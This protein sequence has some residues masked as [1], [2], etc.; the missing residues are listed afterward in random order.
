METNIH[1]DVSKNDFQKYCDTH[2]DSWVQE[3]GFE[4]GR[5]TYPDRKINNTEN[6]SMK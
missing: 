2:Y 3:F 4:T 5:L 1:R 6:V